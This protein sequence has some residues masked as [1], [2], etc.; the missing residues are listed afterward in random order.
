MNLDILIFT[1]NKAEEIGEVFSNEFLLRDYKKALAKLHP[2]INKSRAATDAY[3]KLIQ[4]KSEFDKGKILEDDAG[5]FEEK[6]GLFYFKGDKPFLT[7]S[8]ENYLMLKGKRDESSLSFHKYLPDSMALSQEL[9]VSLVKRA[10]PISKLVL[11]QE[12]V[13]W[14]L[15]RMLEVSAWF[16]QIGYVH[17]GI[18]P[19][20]V[21]IVPETHGIIIS[22]FYHLTK[23]NLK[24]KTISGK[25]KNWYPKEVF[26]NKR[27]KS[28]I[29]VELS[30]RTAA[31]LLGD[32][33]GMGIKL[34]RSHHPALIEFLL[35]RHGNPIDCYD[36]YRK[37]LKKN[38]KVKFHELVI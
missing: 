1:I 14:V 12:H 31:Y 23:A 20:S 25:Y 10:V 37:M 19:E 5:F 9:K 18:N 35:K 7:L 38:F 29:D 32:H 3:I 8:Y 11:P 34:R 17:C 26:D 27:A 16:S 6:D 24:I 21:F 2:D 36:S 4:L 22:T 15:S 28:K 13:L 30:K 33:S